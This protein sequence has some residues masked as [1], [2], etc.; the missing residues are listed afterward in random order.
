GFARKSS[1]PLRRLSKTSAI[2]SLRTAGYTGRSPAPAMTWNSVMSISP[3]SQGGGGSL[4]PRRRW[5]KAESRGPLSALPE[6]DSSQRDLCRPFPPHD[7]LNLRLDRE[8][9]KG[10]L[11]GPCGRSSVVERKLPKLDV[12]GSIPIARS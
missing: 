6:K 4:G 7:R 2:R 1:R 9:V 5:S 12:V 8:P 10:N 11:R 3:H